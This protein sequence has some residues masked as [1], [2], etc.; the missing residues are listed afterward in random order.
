[1]K[2][3]FSQL[4]AGAI[5][6]GT[7]GTATADEAAA[8]AVVVKFEKR[9]E[10]YE[11]LLKAAKTPE[12]REQLLAGK[13]DPN[14]RAKDLF[15]AMKGQESKPWVLPYFAWIFRNCTELAP[16]QTERLRSVFEKL[17]LRSPGAGEVALALTNLPDQRSLELAE[18]VLAKHPDKREQG[19]AAMAVAYFLKFLGEDPKINQRRLRLIRQAIKDAADMPAADQTVGDVAAAELYSIRF[20]EKGGRA[21]DFTATTVEDQPITLS[22]YLGK[23]PVVLVFWASQVK[24]SKQTADF[25][26]DMRLALPESKVEIIGVMTD[27]RDFVRNL[28]A[29]GEVT[30]PSIS[31]P[32][33]KIFEIFRTK[34]LPFCMVI[35]QEGVVRYTGAVGSF[36]QLTAEGLVV[37][38]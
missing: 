31:D 36:A 22:S 15:R 35:D 38:E 17:H 26:R 29:V 11:T 14:Y 10:A 19:Q 23:K 5:A 8:R 12:E 30:W 7:L 25:L 34:Q 33:L 37:E 28:I 1:M 21:P 3:I 9:L 4:C 13:P 32:D 18:M 20:L 6:V 2:R 27:E 24:G 16:N